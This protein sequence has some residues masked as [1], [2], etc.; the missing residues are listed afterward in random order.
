MLSHSIITDTRA[1]VY[2]LLYIVEFYH[3]WAVCAIYSK[4]S[5]PDKY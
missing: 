3:T 1:M 2:T 4:N 5:I